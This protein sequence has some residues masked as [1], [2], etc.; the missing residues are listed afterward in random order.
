M[1][2]KLPADP[3]ELNQY[4][5]RRAKRHSGWS[6]VVIAGAGILLL[7]WLGARLFG[8]CNGDDSLI[9]TCKSYWAPVPL[10]LLLLLPIGL[11]FAEI[12]T[13]GVFAVKTPVSV[14]PGYAYTLFRQSVQ[15]AGGG[16]LRFVRMMSGAF[17]RGVGELKGWERIFVVGSLLFAMAF[18]FFGVWLIFFSPILL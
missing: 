3:S 12:W 13:L 14:A 2:S 11:M 6:L 15:E 17:L 5:R 16:R 8:H 4:H 1:A 10:L 18:F 7:V 9:S